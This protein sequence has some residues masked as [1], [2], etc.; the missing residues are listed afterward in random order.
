M[1]PAEPIKMPLLNKS[2]NINSDKNHSFTLIIQILNS[3]IEIKTS[4]QDGMIKHNYE[5]QFTLDELKENKYLGLC[6]T[7]EE[8]Y[9]QLIILLDRN[10]TIIIEETNLI[11]ISI[12]VDHLKVKEILLTVNEINKSDSEKIDELYNIIPKMNREL[13]KLKEE[14]KKIK[15]ENLFLKEKIKEFSL[16]IPDLL[17]IKTII[18]IEKIINLNSI[19][20]EDNIIYNKTLKNWINPNKKIKSE[21]LYR[22]S[23]DG[24]EYSTFHELCDNKGP[25]IIL[26]KLIDG[27]IIGTYTPLDWDSCTTPIWKSDVN[28]FVFSLTENEKSKKS[29]ENNYGILCYSNYGPFSY[30]LQYNTKCKMDT[31]YIVPENS[32]FIDC[33]KLFPVK[34][35]GYYDISEV[36]VHQIIIDD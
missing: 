23:R 26:I 35:Q 12:P 20:L 28:M 11:Y 9:E 34:E 3:T 25:T 15:E 10:Q 5:K 29:N 8:V 22:M 7:I 1:E 33:E 14:N 2:Y 16:Y 30:F 18:E 17:E 19:I 21:L 6:E 4:Y 27:D 13:E 36:E 32:S 31:I 24:N